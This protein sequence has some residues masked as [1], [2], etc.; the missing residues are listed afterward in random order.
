M[1]LKRGLTGIPRHLDK[2]TDD[3]KNQ[4]KEESQVESQQVVLI[5]RRLT[6]VRMRETFEKVPTVVSLCCVKGN[7]GALAMK[8]KDSSTLKQQVGIQ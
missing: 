2:L 5:T 8:R 1:K 3:D 7:A 4:G 6:I